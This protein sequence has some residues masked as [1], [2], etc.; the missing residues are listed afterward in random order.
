MK[1]STKGR[2]GVRALL[3]VALHQDESPVQLKDIAERQQISLSYLE[4][5]IAPLVAAG[6]L[7]SARGARGG[8]SLGKLARDICLL[9]VVQ[10]LE[11]SLAPVHCVDEPETCS[12]SEACVTRDVWAEVK[13]AV[14]S[15]LGS[16][17][18]ADLVERQGEKLHREVCDN[19]EIA[20]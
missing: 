20:D 9:D 3:D 10:T 4:H 2:Y 1:L 18:L 8:V 5:L 17:T 13:G 16:I 15:V 11:G 7:K 19:S 12:R 6:L 14:E